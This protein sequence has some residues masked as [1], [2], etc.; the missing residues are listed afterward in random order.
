MKHAKKMEE[1]WTIQCLDDEWY[2]TIKT[3]GF[4]ETSSKTGNGTASIHNGPRN[5][6]SLSANLLLG[7]WS[8][9]PICSFP[10]DARF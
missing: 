3:G 5:L 6:H 4:R 9:H 10:N 7:Q 2:K 1:R 8:H